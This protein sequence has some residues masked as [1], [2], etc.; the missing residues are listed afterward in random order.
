MSASA[1]A[2]SYK[3]R[4]RVL[5]VVWL[6]K[7]CDRGVADGAGDHETGKADRPQ[8]AQ[9]LTAK[10]AAGALRVVEHCP[11]SGTDPPPLPPT[12]AWWIHEQASTS[13]SRKRWISTG[14]AGFH[15]YHW[16]SWRNGTVQGKLVGLR[17]VTEQGVFLPESGVCMGSDQ[18]LGGIGVSCWEADFRML[19]DHLRTTTRAQM[20][21]ESGMLS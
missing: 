18:R 21:V 17:T 9:P 1:G 13:P 8:R 15:Y 20:V 7:L 6:D 14:K 16:L 11:N 19:W 2:A 4:A 5:P 10:I 3:V 12:S